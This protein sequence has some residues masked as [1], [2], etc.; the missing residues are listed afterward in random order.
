MHFVCAEA[1]VALYTSL[2]GFS[3]PALHY[4][5]WQCKVKEEKS[6]DDDSMHP[7]AP[8]IAKRDGPVPACKPKQDGRE[9]PVATPSRALPRP[10]QATPSSK[11]ATP[12]PVLSTYAASEG[13]TAN[14]SE[15]AYPKRTVPSKAPSRAPTPTPSTPARS[16]HLSAP[17]TGTASCD[18]SSND[19]C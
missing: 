10:S 1:R 19:A 4:Q 12:S 8:K 7:P 2:N 18:E 6:D 15:P 16:A 17:S 14:E 11:A 3:L 5:C 13:S 9:R